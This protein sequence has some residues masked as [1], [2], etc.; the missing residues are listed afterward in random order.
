MDPTEK[1][2]SITEEP[3]MGSKV[4]KYSPSPHNSVTFG[5]SSEAAALTT[6]EFYRC[7][8][9]IFSASI[10]TSDYCFPKVFLV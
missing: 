3:S 1:L 5:V 2:V 7:L 4:T 6:P 10:S 9:I 8:K